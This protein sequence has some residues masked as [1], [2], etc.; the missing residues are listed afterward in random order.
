MDVISLILGVVGGLVIG[1]LAVWLLAL[2][3]DRAAQDALIRLEAEARAQAAEA[4]RLLAEKQVAEARWEALQGENRELDR[5]LANET[6]RR[7]AEAKALAERV[8]E[9]KSLRRDFETA[10]KALSADALQTNNTRFLELAGQVFA[11]AQATSAGDLEKRQTA[12]RE[13]VSPLQKALEAVA[14]RIGE[15]EKARVGAYEG[16]REQVRGLLEAQGSLRQETGNLVQALRAPHVRGRWGEMQLARTVEFAGM[17]E[18]VDFSPQASQAGADGA[19]RPDLVVH[20]PGGKSIVVDAKAPLDAYLRALEET[21]ADRQRAA[22]DQHA[23]QIRDHIRKLSAKEYWKQFQPTPEMVV[24]FLPGEVFFS[25][26]LQ[27][28]PALIETGASENVLLATPTTLIAL[29]RAVRF[30]WRQERI[31]EEALAVSRLGQELYDR[32]RTLGS[33]FQ[34]TAR[35]LNQTVSHFNRA[36]QSLDSRVMVTARR[37]AELKVAEGQEIPEVAPI[38]EEAGTSQSPEL[39]QPSDS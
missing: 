33:H 30:G 31:A 35:S 7:E 23:R 32:V 18:H 11:K 2:A 19:L 14:G 4:E 15:I 21:D 13:L 17:V 29:L 10:F 36:M 1:G 3:R 8:E 6:T 12:I 38:L 22:L 39:E 25:A 37:F 26:A 24:L 16:L 5:R 20:L 28:D 34:Q 27:Q 9:L